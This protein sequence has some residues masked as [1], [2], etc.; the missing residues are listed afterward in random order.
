MLYR[1]DFSTMMD[2]IDLVISLLYNVRER[3]NDRE[4][5]IEYNESNVISLNDNIE[6]KYVPPSESAIE[7]N[8]G[9]HYTGREYEN[10]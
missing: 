6:F 2:N 7:L 3:I 9:R 5:L 1:S 10:Y 4:G 8:K